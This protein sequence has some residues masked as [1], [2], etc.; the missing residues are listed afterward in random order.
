[1]QRPKWLS[2]WGKGNNLLEASIIIDIADIKVVEA[3]FNSKLL[4]FAVGTTQKSQRTLSNEGREEE[5]ESKSEPDLEWKVFYD[6][7]VL[8]QLMPFDKATSLMAGI[9]AL[10]SGKTSV[11]DK[12]TIYV[13]SGSRPSKGNTPV[14]LDYDIA[15]KIE[16]AKSNKTS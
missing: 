9:V 7:T 10:S 15:K 3:S 11:Y 1:M 14:L 12:N 6:S 13:P 2:G 5:R 16:E 8:P 4:L